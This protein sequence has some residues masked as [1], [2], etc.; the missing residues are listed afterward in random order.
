MST[1]REAK[2]SAAFLS[3]FVSIF[4]SDLTTRAEASPE[5]FFAAFTAATAP[6]NTAALSI[7]LQPAESPTTLKAYSAAVSTSLAA[8]SLTPDGLTHETAFQT[9]KLSTN[10]TFTHVA[11][12][13]TPFEAAESS[14]QPATFQSTLSTTEPS[15]DWDSFI[16]T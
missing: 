14:T 6:P 9:A 3:Y 16:S 12:E 13:Q 10:R 5:T 15:S 4:I 8:T 7:S 11:A 2:P 1:K